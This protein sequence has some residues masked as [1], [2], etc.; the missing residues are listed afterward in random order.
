MSA[1]SWD[2]DGRTWP[3]AGASR[4]VDGGGFHWHVQVMGQGPDLLLIHGTAASTHS[5]HR[6]A[7]ILAE[8]FR[9]IVPDLPGHGFT[10]A[11][12]THRFTL[13]EMAGAIASLLE[14]LN[15][16]PS[17]AAGHSAGAAILCRM[18]LDKAIAPAALISLNGALLP[19]KG[20]ASHIFPALARLVFINPF[21]PA[22]FSWRA[23]DKNAVRRLIASTGSAIGPD[24]LA[25]YARLFQTP[26]HVKAALSM[27]ANWDLHA[28]ER[29]LPSLQ[30]PLTL[31]TGSRDT[32]VSPE[33]AFRVKELVRDSRLVLQRGLG[34]L[35]HEEKPDES[36]RAIFEAAERAGL[37]T[38]RSRELSDTSGGS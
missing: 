22:F 3:N 14:T 4:F 9:L 24:D 29:D 30:T 23:N 36:A 18:A 20:I 27:M 12:P 8:R 7:P 11:A 28:L 15:A 38:D 21:V 35:G 34:H 25:L 33:V 1:L 32:A 17:L 13:P 16:K 37:H 31:V 10:K 5:W 2:V 26:E 19:F 6:L